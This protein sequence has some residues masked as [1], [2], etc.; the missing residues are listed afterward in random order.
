MNSD[1]PK[2]I[3]YDYKET[4]DEADEAYGED[5]DPKEKSP[6][7][8]TEH[9]LSIIKQNLNLD[10]IKDRKINNIIK[11]AINDIKKL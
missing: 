10:S 7:F 4:Y 1:E 5:Q 8:T 9:Y 3:G 2:K 11:K 6:G